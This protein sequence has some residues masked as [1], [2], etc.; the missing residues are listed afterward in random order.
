VRVTC[1]GLIAAFL[2]AWP[3]PA[4]EPPEAV[5]PL[6]SDLVEEVETRILRLDVSVVDRKTSE[7]RSVPGLTREMFTLRMGFRRMN[8]EAYARVAFDEV[9]AEDRT[10]I[11][12]ELRWHPVVVMLDFNYLD[13][14]MRLAAARA[15]RALADE[16]IPPGFRIKVLGYTR[17]LYEIQAFTRNPDDL[18]SAA[19]FIEAAPW[20][21]RRV[22]RRRAADGFIPRSTPLEMLEAFAPEESVE[23]QETEGIEDTN[24]GSQVPAG[25]QEEQTAADPTFGGIIPTLDMS[26]EVLADPSRRFSRLSADQGDN[27]FA[28]SASLAA[29]PQSPNRALVLAGN[30]DP[31]A[32]LAALEAVLRGH[33]GLRGRKALI[34]FTGEAFSLP[35]EDML[36]EARS[37]LQ[38]A[39]DGFTLWI[40]DARGFSEEGALPHQRSD[41][42]TLLASNSGGETLR[43]ASDLSLVFSRVRESLDCYYLFS[44]P[45]PAGTDARSYNVSVHL[46][47][48]D[49]PDLWRYTVRHPTRLR[50]QDRRTARER[51]RTAALL[52][53]EGWH[54][55]PVR[56]ELTF[57]VARERKKS[58]LPVEIS[59][60]LAAL[61]FRP[62][63][64]GGYQAEFLVDAAVDRNGSDTI[65]LLPEK[66][67][68]IL[69]RIRLPQAPAL[70][71]RGHLVIRDFCPY[72]GHGVYSLRASLSDS[73]QVDPGAT[74]ATYIIEPEPGEALSITAL[75]AGHNTGEDYLLLD[76]SPG[77]VEVPQDV[78]RAAFIPLEEGD[79]AAT[80]DRLLFRYVV[81][82]PSRQ[83]AKQ[84]LRRLVYRYED[85]R[86]TLLFTLPD[87]REEQA[88]GD[89]AAPPDPF[90]VE[91]QDA[92]PPETLEAGAYGFAVIGPADRPL[93][94]SHI[95]QVLVR[96]QGDPLLGRV[97]F[98]VEVLATPRPRPEAQEASLN[99]VIAPPVAP[100]AIHH[101]V[102]HRT[103]QSH[104]RFPCT[105]ANVPCCP[106]SPSSS[107]G[108]RSGP[109]LRTRTRDPGS[110]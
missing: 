17:S 65:C 46:N 54:G 7:R 92:L 87:A 86:P 88:P 48:R 82:G 43:S 27:L 26:P 16:G 13:G 70:G 85:G 99:D 63:S 64:E 68:A 51:R 28:L 34:L 3:A 45:V 14:P 72:R 10:R 35:R 110:S 19:A 101:L 41:L 56:A 36:R 108:E 91:I 24:P 73:G 104:W 12:P 20:L 105:V 38:A 71:Y 25:Y 18:R 57:P 62:A 32:S 97:E 93:E 5:E 100:A 83:E 89:D 9:C 76:P 30:W 79:A 40:V 77:Q 80:T 37:V 8:Q 81:C 31:R 106:L 15:I 78:A 1:L 22:L 90:C 59:V 44:I 33:A 94:R 6:P 11:P 98:R 58:V 102:Y 42:I 69:H 75:R 107:W 55:L 66:G 67:E 53:P 96:G 4:Q 49:Y 47:I 2:C 29:L 21:G 39:Q 52:N 84:R 74:R 50:L 95:E 103:S 23:V 109:P 61:E 60:P